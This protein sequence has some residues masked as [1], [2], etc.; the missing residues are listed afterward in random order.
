M[1]KFLVTTENIK[2]TRS[3]DSN[4]NLVKVVQKSSWNLLFAISET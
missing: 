2:K 4:Y 3:E 1:L